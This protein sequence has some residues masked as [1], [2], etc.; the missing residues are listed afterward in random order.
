MLQVR[1]VRDGNGCVREVDIQ[2]HAG[3]AVHGQDPACAAASLLAKAYALT[4][5]DDKRHRVQ[6]DIPNPGSF[7]LAITQVGDDEHALVAGTMLMHGL[8]SIRREFPQNI[9]IEYIKQS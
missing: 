2:G 4:I 7:F 3:V 5:A 8:E 9:T 1:I 6:A